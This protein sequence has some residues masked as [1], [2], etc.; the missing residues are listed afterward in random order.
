MA[1]Y[2][3]ETFEP[4]VRVD[5][6]PDNEEHLIALALMHFH[7]RQHPVIRFKLDPTK[8]GN[9]YMAMVDKFLRSRMPI[10]TIEQANRHSDS[11]K[12]LL[13]G[14]IIDSP[15][16]SRIRLVANGGECCE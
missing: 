8:Y 3:I 4:P 9:V 5:F 16:E 12:P 1:T 7:G 2:G 13:V 14:T 11:R 10:E 15:N 6:D